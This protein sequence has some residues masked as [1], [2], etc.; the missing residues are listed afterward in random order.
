[1]GII[2]SNI[3]VAVGTVMFLFTAFIYV[4]II[5][6]CHHGSSPLKQEDAI[7]ELNDVSSIIFGMGV[8]F[9][10]LGLL[11][12]LSYFDKYNVCL[13]VLL[14]VSTLYWVYNNN[15]HDHKNTLFRVHEIEGIMR[16]FCQILERL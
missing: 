13:Y 1:M 4:S 5:H 10:W 7:F 11:R 2:F 3:L 9:Q 15:A 12:F 8:F 6:A 16:A 14:C